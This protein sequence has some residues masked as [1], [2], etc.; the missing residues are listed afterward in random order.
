MKAEDHIQWVGAIAT[1]PLSLETCLRYFLLRLLKQDP[2]FPKFGDRDAKKTYMTRQLSLGN[3]V[4][5]YNQALKKT[6]QNSRSGPNLCSF[7]PPLRMGG[8]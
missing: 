4:K 2:Q 1:N 7:A 6:K 8:S 5:N 3:T